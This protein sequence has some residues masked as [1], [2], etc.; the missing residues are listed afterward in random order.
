MVLLSLVVM[1]CTSPRRDIPAIAQIYHDGAQTETRNPVIVIHGV[2]GARLVQRS[3]GKTVWG[4]FTHEAID[5][6][7]PEGVRAISLPFLIPKTARYDPEHEDV[8]A[9]MPL[10]RL[11]IDVSLG[12]LPVNVDVYINILRTL[13][14][15]GYRDPLVVDPLA[16][17][18]ADDHFT[19]FT[20]FYDWRRDNVSNALLLHR[21]IQAKRS[22]IQ[23]TAK[24]K[25]QRL[26]TQGTV[27]SLQRAAAME[28]WLRTGYKFDIVTHSMGGLLSRYY[29]RYG[30]QDLPSNGSP[31]EITWAGSKEI[32]RLILIAT[33]NFGSMD[34]FQSLIRGRRFAPFLPL[35][36]A[37]LL[38]SMPALYQLLPRNR[39]G[40]I[41]DERGRP[42]DLDLF[43]ARVWKENGWGLMAS[44]SD[45]VLQWMMPEMECQERRRERAYTYLNWCLQRAR[46]FH[47]SLDIKTSLPCSTSIYLFA[48]DAEPTLS[49]V[50]M[51]YTKG[52]LEP[53]FNRGDLYSPGD[54][55]VPRYSA[56][57]DERQGHAYHKGLSSPIPWTNITFLSDDHL[58]LTRNPHFINNMLFILFDWKKPNVA[59]I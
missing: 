33:P 4:A 5:L 32:D 2:L 11:K 28:S 20:F 31:P 6:K 14:V 3:T 29:L 53:L 35:Y 36:P 19:C 23:R 52:H 45:R 8:Y 7:T 58:G 22:E 1:G 34:A 10:E 9:A 27:E 39:H 59:E 41:L 13:G 12:V 47:Q 30:A 46:R 15:G 40:L 49:H 17:H 25:I 16:P 56:V 37:A 26:R 38:D 54:G 24:L 42:L 43:D 55:I 18:Y 48:A 50:R 44:G 51:R 21:F 57:G